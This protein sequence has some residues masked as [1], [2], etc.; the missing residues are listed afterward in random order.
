MKNTNVINSQNKILFA[1]SIKNPPQ[2]IKNPPQPMLTKPKFCKHR[3]LY[4]PD[5]LS[6]SLSLS[7]SPRNNPHPPPSTPLVTSCS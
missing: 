3:Y 7:L 6:L 1:I 4:S 2:P 5:L